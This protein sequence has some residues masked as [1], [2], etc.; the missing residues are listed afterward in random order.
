[1]TS[2]PGAIAPRP[3]LRGSRL[4]VGL[5]MTTVGLVFFLASCAPTYP[6]DKVLE[7]VVHLCR[8]EYHIDI[9]A[10]IS[11]TTIGVLIPV[12]G[13]FEG[14]LENVREEDLDRIAQ[15]LQFSEHGRQNIEDVALSLARV[16]LSSDAKLEFYT[17]VARD[18]PT[19]LEFLWSGYVTDQK[20]V[21]LDISRGDFLQ[22]RTPISFR[23]QPERIAQYTVED[24]LEDLPERPVAYLLRHYV[25]PSATLDQ[26]LPAMLEITALIVQSG[27]PRGN[28]PLSAR[29]LQVSSKEVLVHV[30]LSTTGDG[31]E[32]PHPAYLFAV[33]LPGRGGLIHSI[34]RLSDPNKLPRPYGSW[35]SLETWKEP[36]YLEAL[37]LPE[38]L[39]EQIAR[40]IRIDMTTSKPQALSPL[41]LAVAGTFQ[42]QSFDFHF[43]YLKFQKSHRSSEDLALAVVKTA[44]EVLNSYG[45]KDFQTLRVTDLL[46]G[47]SWMVSAQDLP[48]YRRRNPPPLSLLH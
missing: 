16:I 33:H 20:R 11:G 31:G 21:S 1:M 24:F 10:K 13:L 25:A 47:K 2:L 45:F 46:K 23:M 44:A 36:F 14:V 8:Q 3:S 37:S 17:I 4:K 18:V 9:Q 41:E 42:D 39:A 12:K 6:K 48:L 5:A 35:G 30:R 27:N 38:F 7:S 29:A 15:T 22:Y 40:R 32:K 26:I 28:P 34:E 43:R 19:G